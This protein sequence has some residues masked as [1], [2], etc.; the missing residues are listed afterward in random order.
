MIGILGWPLLGHFQSCRE[1]N[2]PRYTYRQELMD[3]NQI[4]SFTINAYLSYDKTGLNLKSERAFAF[5]LENILGPSAVTLHFNRNITIYY[6]RYSQRCLD[7]RKHSEHL[8]KNSVKTVFDD[9]IL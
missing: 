3:F 2:P 6:H 4:Q 7:G 1:S 9:C 5:V 8:K